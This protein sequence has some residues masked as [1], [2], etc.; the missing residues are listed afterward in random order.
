VNPVTSI[1]PP[2]AVVG[3]LSPSLRTSSYRR[4]KPRLRSVP[5]S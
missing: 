1:D 4:A 3:R 2:A 5:R